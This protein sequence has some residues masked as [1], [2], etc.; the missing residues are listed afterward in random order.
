MDNTTPEFSREVDVPPSTKDEI[1]CLGYPS[2][3]NIFERD[4][5]VMSYNLERKVAKWV[6][7]CLTSN[8]LNHS[9]LTRHDAIEFK[10]DRGINGVASLADCTDWQENNYERGHLAAAANHRYNRKAYYSTF[11]IS[12]IAPMHKKVNNLIS[13][14]ERQG[15]KFV[16]DYGNVHIITGTIFHTERKEPIFVREGSEVQVPD[17]IFKILAI[18][19]ER[20]RCKVT[21]Y[22]IENSLDVDDKDIKNSRKTLLEIRYLTGLNLLSQVPKENI[23]EDR[24]RNSGC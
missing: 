12:N 1:M 6:Q 16:K 7:E 11:L 18:K 4:C 9:Y 3:E 21:G 20:N 13:K 22:V 23:V 2:L 14:I 17:A 10:E 24:I 15:R 19:D 5:Y 8:H